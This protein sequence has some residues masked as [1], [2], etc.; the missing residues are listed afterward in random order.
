[1]DLPYTYLDDVTHTM[2]G[3][4]RRLTRNEY[5]TE[6]AHEKYNKKGFKGISRSE[7]ASLC[8]CIPFKL[9]NAK[10]RSTLYFGMHVIHGL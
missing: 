5:T 9:Q 3:Q 4:R 1:M 8:T 7:R 2:K 10:N 6:A